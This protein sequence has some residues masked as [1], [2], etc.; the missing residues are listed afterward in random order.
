M[1]TKRISTLVLPLMSAVCVVLS[2]SRSTCP[3]NQ[4]LHR[5]YDRCCQYV[6]CKPQHY[7]RVCD[8]E[9]GADVCV[10][11][12]P[13]A[14]LDD[15]TNSYFVFDCL[16]KTCGEDTVP[17][18]SPATEFNGSACSKRC[19]CN[20]AKNYCGTDPCRCRYTLC[21]QGETLL[22]NCTCVRDLLST[23]SATTQ[24]VKVSEPPPVIPTGQPPS[25][26]T[27][28][29]PVT[30]DI[31][32]AENGGKTSIDKSDFPDDPGNVSEPEKNKTMIIIAA[33][34]VGVLVVGAIGAVYIYQRRNN[35]SYLNIIN[36]TNNKT[37]VHNY[38]DCNVQIG[39]K[40]TQIVH[41]FVS[42]NES[43]S[44]TDE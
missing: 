21:S 35:S 24:E 27:D 17:I 32:E 15:P 38:Q 12:G 33:V 37:R 18:D 3:R 5:N 22:Q 43:A 19:R 4:V 16:E 44:S 13:N 9:G 36:V 11:C 1:D 25:D 7:V 6:S 31:E 20:P 39:D 29:D 40:N 14:Y 26:V 8:R 34:S 41:E 2:Q 42:E 30:E 28:S 23:P 10:P